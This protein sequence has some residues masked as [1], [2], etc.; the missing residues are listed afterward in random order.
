MEPGDSMLHSQGLSNNPYP[1]PKTQFP[2][3]IPISSRSILI[4]SFHLRLGF[5][6]ELFPVNS[7]NVKIL[8]IHYFFNPI[9]F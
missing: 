2:A 5:P 7:Y 1:E 9:M 3:L 4:L 6:K 8:I